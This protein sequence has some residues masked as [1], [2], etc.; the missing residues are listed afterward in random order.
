[1]KRDELFRTMG[2]IDEKYIKSAEA[3]FRDSKGKAVAG[4]VFKVL[5]YAASIAL[6]IG[7]ALTLW[8]SS[9]IHKDPPAAAVTEYLKIYINET[10]TDMTAGKIKDGEYMI[11]FVA[12]MQYVTCTVT[13]ESDTVCTFVYAGESYYIDVKNRSAGPAEDRNQNYLEIPPG[14][15]YGYIPYK[16]EDHELYVEE[17]T[18]FCFFRSFLGRP[19]SD[20]SHFYKYKDGIN[21]DIRLYNVKTDH[22]TGTAA[23]SETDPATTEPVTE[24]VTESVTEPATEAVTESATTESAPQDPESLLK[25]YI[26]EYPTDMKAEKVK[27]GEYM[28]PFVSLIKYVSKS[29]NW[30]SDT[31]CTFNYAEKPF[32]IDIKNH[33]SGPAN[34]RNADYLA[35][36]PGSDYGYVPYRTEDHELY[37]E[38]NIVFCF[39]RTVLRDLESNLSHFAEYKDGINAYIMIG[40]PGTLVTLPVTV[41][42]ISITAP[43]TSLEVGE[44][45]KL[46]AAVKPDNADNKSVKWSVSSGSSYGKVSSDGTFTALKA[47]VCTVKATVTDGSDVSAAV[48]ITVTEPSPFNKNGYKFIVNGKDIS[49]TV[50]YTVTISGD[51]VSGELPLTAIFR[52][53]GRKVEW[54]DENTVTLTYDAPS[55]TFKIAEVYMDGDDYTGNWFEQKQVETTAYYKYGNELYLDID[56]VHVFVSEFCGGG[57][58]VDTKAKTVT[59][60]DFYYE[61]AE[62]PGTETS[63]AEQPGERVLLDTFEIEVL[64]YIRYHE[65]YDRSSTV[66]VKVYTETEAV[67]GYNVVMELIGPNGGAVSELD[68]HGCG[69]IALC[70]DGLF[71]EIIV[72]LVTVTPDK[73]VTAVTRQF[74]ISDY[75]M[76]GETVAPYFRLLTEVTPREIPDVTDPVT[77]RDRAVWFY[78]DTAEMLNT[79]YSNFVIRNNGS[80]YR[81]LDFDNDGYAFYGDHDHP[82]DPDF[83]N[84]IG[85][86]TISVWLG[87]YETRKR[88]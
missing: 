59:V 29:L 5:G 50:G 40:A 87:Y 43:K 38:A 11:P 65:E 78:S 9:V 66:R 25:I 57:L 56:S 32:Y 84:M 55:Y 8:I 46:T 47:G 42:S 58:R 13:W 22:D 17:N 75:N 19:L 49:D 31:V 2:N 70:G 33:T 81:I 44:T 1:M 23:L 74:E 30:E 3:H 12:L 69:F 24:P 72:H 71:N 64:N 60:K 83:I 73:R 63:P 20:Y 36:P 54:K 7:L 41:S 45:V 52:A 37:V 28:I 6:I 27:D 67:N 10:Q 48:K 15:D 77:W 85:G 18:I 76:Y 86:R 21:A 80:F 16:T 35:L 53:F 79:F 4:T 14:S 34:N 39:F 61:E 26:N 82:I 62:D 88:P 51:K 68:L